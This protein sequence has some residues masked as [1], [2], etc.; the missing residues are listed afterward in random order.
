MNKRKWFKTIPTDLTRKQLAVLDLIPLDNNK[1]IVVA[2]FLKGPKPE[3][4]KI[5]L[6]KNIGDLEG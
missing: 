4:R 5:V 3:I 2:K 6:S 1:A